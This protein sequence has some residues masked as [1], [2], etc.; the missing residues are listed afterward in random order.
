MSKQRV[1]IERHLRVERQHVSGRRHDQRVDLDQGRVDRVEHGVD[2]H[3][4]RRRLAG[5]R[6]PQTDTIGQASR[7]ECGQPDARIDRHLVD[8]LWRLGRHLLDL[9]APGGA[10]HHQEPLRRPVDQETEVELARDV[11]P[12]LDQEPGHPL[13][14]GTGLRGDQRHP[15]HLARDP[16]CVLGGLGQLDAAALAAP[17]GMNLGLH[18]DPAPETACGVPGFGSRRDHLTPRRGDAVAREQRL[19]LVFVDFHVLNG[20]RRICSAICLLGSADVKRTWRSPSGFS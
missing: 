13:P 16:S 12:L 19:P 4:Q 11:E 14:S 15:E 2:A 10:G 17:A 1:V 7:L 18:D 8:Q 20:G 5:R 3:H 6:P 9:H